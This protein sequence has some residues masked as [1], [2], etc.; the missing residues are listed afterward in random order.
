MARTHY[1]L[2]SSEK[3]IALGEAISALQEDWAL[4]TNID[5]DV[6]IAGI[7][8]INLL[9]TGMHLLQEKVP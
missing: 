6:Y 9:W 4:D 1:F 3:M 2:P 8:R 5:E 7:Q